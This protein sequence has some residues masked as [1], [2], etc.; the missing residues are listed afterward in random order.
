MISV[1]TVVAAGSAFTA[2][3]YII[4]KNLSDGDRMSRRE[5]FD[6][7][8]EPQKH[9]ALE[10]PELMERVLIIGDI[11]GCLDEL[12]DL[13]HASQYD[14]ETTSVVL[15]GDLVNKVMLLCFEHFHHFCLQYVSCY[16]G[17]KSA[18]C[19]QY[20]RK[21]GFYSV[22]GNHDVAAIE[23]YRSF[24]SSG[25]IGKKKYEYIKALSA[26]D[27]AWYSSLPY[28][29]TLPDFGCIVVHAGLLP[30]LRLEDQDPH[31]MVTMRNIKHDFT[32][33]FLSMERQTDDSANWAE[34]WQG[35]HV[36]YGHD[37]K[38]GY[39]MHENATGLDTGCAY[40]RK[41]TGIL[42]PEKRV[43]EVPARMVYLDSNEKKRKK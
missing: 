1:L 34:L 24:K 23:E 12:L 35:M 27:F 25:V 10:S 15:V 38:R 3:I 42:L 29:I 8:T 13:L 28:T 32:G 39:Q 9:I 17:P 33:N 2:V 14:P 40:G 21:H 31:D 41:L 37:A 6:T 43:I 36:Y 22:L 16:Q 20:C 26:D 7:H 4:M 19:I 11:H 18:E 5:L 30:N